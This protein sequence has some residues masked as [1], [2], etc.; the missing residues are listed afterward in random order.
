MSKDGYLPPGVEEYMIPGNRPEDIL[1]EKILDETCGKCPCRNV[2]RYYDNPGTHWDN[3]EECPCVKK[4]LEAAHEPPYWM[5][6]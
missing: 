4:A 5:V 3:P 6:D 1:F 2:C